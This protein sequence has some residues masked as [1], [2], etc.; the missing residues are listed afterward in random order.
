[1]MKSY[2]A[3][4]RLLHALFASMIVF[5]LFSEEMMKRPKLV[6]G[7]PRIRTDG[8][9]FFFEM[10]EWFGIA[11]LLIVGLRVA[12]MLGSADEMRRLMPFFSCQRM[13]GVFAELKEIP[14]WFVGKLRAPGEEDNLSGFIHGLGLLLA[15]AMAITGTAMFFG[16]HEID[17]TMN[18]FVHT[19]KELHEVLGELLWY[20]VIAHVAMGLFHQVKGHR[21]LQR[22]S[23]F[24]KE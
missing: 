13:Q 5:Q 3:V 18:G 11:L 14:G 10:H 23:P 24:S 4:N 21:S 7:V 19:M 20:Y 2:P 8:Q 22:I 6:D 1:M 12:L 16:M 15:L 17:G 9:I